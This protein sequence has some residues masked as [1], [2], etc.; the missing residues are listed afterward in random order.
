MN[1]QRRIDCLD[2][3]GPGSFFL[4]NSDSTRVVILGGWEGRYP[5]R[6]GRGGSIGEV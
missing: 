5:G 2:R 6:G 3:H 4:P 1:L